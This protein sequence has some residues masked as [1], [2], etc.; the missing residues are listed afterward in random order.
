[1]C[2]TRAHLGSHLEN[3]KRILP[4]VLFCFVY[5][6]W[7]FR[8]VTIGKKVKRNISV[9]MYIHPA[10]DITYS[11]VHPLICLG[12]AILAS[13]RRKANV[14]QG[15]SIAEPPLMAALTA[16]AATAVAAALPKIHV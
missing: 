12:H 4:I 11:F 10:S 5:P 16:A 2:A 15:R 14:V 13:C 1:M 7:G 3:K 9:F 8:V 6:F